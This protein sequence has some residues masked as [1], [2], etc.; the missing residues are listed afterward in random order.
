[1][2]ISYTD[3]GRG[4]L[5]MR[6]EF[7]LAACFA[8]ILGAVSLAEAAIYTSP[9]TGIGSWGVYPNCVYPAVPIEVHSWWDEDD[10]PKV[11]GDSTRYTNDDAPRHIHLAT[12][13]PNARNDGSVSL[14]ANT[15]YPFVM[16]VMS[17]NNPSIIN[18]VRFGFQSSNAETTISTNLSCNTSVASHKYMAGRSECTWYVDSVLA[19]SNTAGYGTNEVRLSPNVSNHVDLGTRQFATLNYQI[20]VNNG[21]TNKYRSNNNN[22][23]RSWYVL[24]DY[25]N[26][27]VNYMDIF[28]MN[29][30]SEN[31]TRT[32]PLVKGVVPIKV[33]GREGNGTLKP[34]IWQNM[35]HHANPTFWKGKATVGTVDPLTGG[36]LVFVGKGQSGTDTFNWDTTK[37]PDGRHKLYFQNAESDEGGISAG[38]MLLFFDVC[39]NGTATTCGSF[40]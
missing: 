33:S 31:K 18:W 17:F 6:P 32:I 26:D 4:S 11:H 5:F 7:S 35:N 28:A 19:T 14:A 23:G 3:A 8:G 20:K 2:S 37:L 38:A 13:L 25:V 21:L 15:K 1:M 40:Q 10:A 16:R 39:N 29:F 9:P 24:L 12:C 22:I 27:S 36:K 30:A 34:I